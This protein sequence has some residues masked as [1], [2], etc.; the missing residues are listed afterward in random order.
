MHQIHLCFE[1][2]R[3]EIIEWLQSRYEVIKTIPQ[4]AYGLFLVD[5]VSFERIVQCIRMIKNKN[6]HVYM[7]VILVSNRADLNK[8]ENRFSGVVDEVL[9][10]PIVITELR[11]RIEALLKA[12]EFSIKAKQLYENE[13]KLELQAKRL[14]NLSKNVPG[15]IYQFAV[16]NQ[17]STRFEYISNGCRE[18]FDVE[19]EEAVKHPQLIISTVHPDERKDYENNLANAIQERRTWTWEGRYIIKG[20]TKWIKGAS[21]PHAESYGFIWDGVMVDVTA[22]KEAEENVRNLALYNEQI[23]ENTNEGILVCDT[24][25]HITTWNHALEKISGIPRSEVIGHHPLE[26]FQF[27]VTQRLH[28]QFEQALYGIAGQTK[29]YWYEFEKSGKSGWAKNLNIPLRNAKGEITGVLCTIDEITISKKAEEELKSMVTN[30]QNKNEELTKMNKELDNANDRLKNIDAIK[31]Q[32]VSTASHEIRTPLT[33]ILGFVQTLRAPGIKIP[34]GNRLE[35]L[36]IIENEA[37]RLS[38][39]VESLLNISRL[40]AGKQELRRNVFFISELISAIRDTI[41]LE[42]RN[43]NI[44]IVEKDSGQVSADSQQIELVIR[45]ILNNA[46]R[47]T[48]PGGTIEVIISRTVKEVI[49]AIKDYGPGIPQ[50]QLQAIFE[51][52]YRIQKDRS[53]IGHGSGLGLSIA[54]EIIKAHNGR[55]WVESNVGEGSTFFFALPLGVNTG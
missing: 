45:N 48:R 31:S 47:Y 54:K 28:L 18:I 12:H 52:F 21:T 29:D 19:P 50:D 41:H 15:M 14:D 42:K 2:Q 3:N 5:S 7:P 53:T 36:K 24:G 27:L 55:I 32:F 39:L 22:L 9:F 8:I 44:I 13:I 17:G 25:M 40:E 4:E 46:V 43:I 20:K 35:Y 16:P 1:S 34:E 10:E 30:L 51:K 49:V 38:Q 37:I 26:F 23:V 33:S 11:L 6:T